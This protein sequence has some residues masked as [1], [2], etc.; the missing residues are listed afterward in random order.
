MMRRPTVATVGIVCISLVLIS[1]C[2][3]KPEEE[4]S[5]TPAAV[6]APSAPGAAGTPAKVP[7]P[8]PGPPGPAGAKTK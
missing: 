7:A 5:P 6:T 2:S 3:K 8:P 1:G 4:A